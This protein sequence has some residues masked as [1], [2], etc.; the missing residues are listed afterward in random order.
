M[1]KVFSFLFSV[2]L[3]MGIATAQTKRPP[4]REVKAQADHVKSSGDDLLHLRFK[5]A[6]KKHVAEARRRNRGIEKDLDGKGAPPPRPSGS[7]IK[8]PPPPPPPHRL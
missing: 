5:K 4:D 3:F 8:L 7:R 2:L 1:K 6:H